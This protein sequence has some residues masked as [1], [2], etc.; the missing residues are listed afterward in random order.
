MMDQ[1]QTDA[2]EDERARRER[3]ARRRRRLVVNRA[4]TFEEAALWDLDFWQSQTPQERLSAFVHLRRDVELV[5][6]ARA[7]RGDRGR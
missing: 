1:R 7:K 4:A 5:E 2:G 6:A 3:A